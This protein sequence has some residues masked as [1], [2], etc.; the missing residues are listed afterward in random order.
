MI[1]NIMIIYFKNPYVDIDIANDN[2]GTRVPN[3][4]RYRLAFA[5]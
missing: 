4:P 2:Y 5:Y 1:I 3:I